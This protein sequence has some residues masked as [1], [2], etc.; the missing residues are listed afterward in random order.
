MKRWLAFLL[1][2]T[3]AAGELA[4][5]A[6]EFFDGL[7]EKLTFASAEGNVHAQLSGYLET[8]AF[9]LE[10][11]APGLLFTEDEFLSI[12]RLALFFDAQIGPALY[13]FAQ[14]NFDQGFD[15]SDG[16]AE[17]RVDEYA[18][19]Y[20]PWRDGRLSVQAGKFATVV[21]NW[22]ARHSAWENPFITAPLPY[23]KLTGMWDI[24]PPD[25]LSTLL[26]WAHVPPFGVPGAEKSDKHLRLPMIWGPAYGSGA[27][28]ALQWRT[29]DF[30][31]EVKNT[32]LSARPES[33]D[34]DDGSWEPPTYSARLGWRPNAMWNLGLSAS[35]GPYLLPETTA[36]PTGYGL[37]DYRQIVL[38]HDLGFAW[39]HWQIWAEF[40]ASRFLI[41]R[42]GDADVYASYVEAKYKFTPRFFGA[43][44][45]GKQN[46]G[47]LTAPDGARFRWGRDTW[48]VE[49]AGTFRVSTQLQLKIQYSLQHEDDSLNPD[50]ENHLWA[51]QATLRF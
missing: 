26:R 4:A 1:G 34:F 46:F 9:L 42:I 21:G 48:K 12:S 39:R 27:A 30:S 20:T 10:Q 50:A 15:P 45:L 47:T 18:L 23:E 6:D 29:F 13:A 8:S 38:G 2:W 7:R 51:A 5:G 49:T 16:P 40:F 17:L 11:P 44:R 36:I 25:K 32:A 14:T 41:P 37:E 33:W 28:M 3:A 43:L 19:R 35:D 24:Q 31:A 22:V